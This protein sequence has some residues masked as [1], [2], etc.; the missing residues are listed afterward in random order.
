MTWA[1]RGGAGRGGAGGGRRRGGRGGA[2]RGV[3]VRPAPRG[4]GETAP[5]RAGSPGLRA[6]LPGVP[7]GAVGRGSRGAPRPWRRASRGG[8]TTETHEP[9][10]VPE[11]GRSSPQRGAARHVPPLRRS[12]RRP[13]ARP[14]ERKECSDVEM[15]RARATPGCGCRAPEQSPRE[16]APAAQ[17]PRDAIEQRLAR[18]TQVK[19]SRTRQWWWVRKDARNLG[20]EPQLFPHCSAA[21]RL[22]FSKALGSWGICVLL[23]STSVALTA[24][25]AGEMVRGAGQCEG[26]RHGLLSGTGEGPEPSGGGRT[27]EGPQVPVLSEGWSGHTPGR[28]EPAATRGSSPSHGRSRGPRCWV[29]VHRHLDT[30]GHLTADRSPPQPYCSGPQTPLESLSALPWLAAP[31][32]SSAPGPWPTWTSVT[33]K[34]KE[35]SRAPLLPLGHPGPGRAPEAEAGARPEPAASLQADPPATHRTRGRGLCQGDVPSANPGEP[36]LRRGPAGCTTEQ[37]PASLQDEPFKAGAV[38]VTALPGAPLTSSSGSIS[39]PEDLKPARKERHL[40][41]TG[42]LVNGARELVSA[43]RSEGTNLGPRESRRAVLALLLRLLVTD[44]CPRGSLCPPLDGGQAAEVCGAGPLVDTARFPGGD[45]AASR[46]RSLLGPIFSH[47]RGRERR[48]H[49]SGFPSGHS[50][51]SDA[52]PGPV[53]RDLQPAVRQGAGGAEGS[54]LQADPLQTRCDLL[55]EG[56]PEEET[57]AGGWGGRGSRRTQGSTWQAGIRGPVIPSTARTLTGHISQG[58]GCS[59]GTG[60]QGQSV[61]EVS[62]ERGPA[63]LFLHSLWPCPPTNFAFSGQLTSGNGSPGPRSAD[64]GQDV[65]ASG[66]RGRL[67]RGPEAASWP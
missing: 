27:A 60:S 65:G 5:T 9:G 40:L 62:P 33:L 37:L 64:R 15:G 25:R 48:G 66:V 61:S 55:R 53:G 34:E 54:A 67:G 56:C 11:K 51:Q 28:P 10:L 23:G 52:G 58:C 13:G 3:L 14:V 59:A 32:T 49:V 26:K 42:T 7:A 36:R 18:S 46:G 12:G 21:A 24:G 44:A 6:L 45:S 8:L 63:L 30:P 50:P 19:K 41:P 31:L 39:A 29:P 43:T 17:I 2:G 20:K 35:P 57:A 4:S 1:G 22:T 38:A 47:Q 16:A